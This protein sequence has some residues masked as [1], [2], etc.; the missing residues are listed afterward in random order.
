MGRGDAPTVLLGT[1]DLEP[2]E[3]DGKEWGVG[4]C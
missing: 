3:N 1:P 2:N 4:S